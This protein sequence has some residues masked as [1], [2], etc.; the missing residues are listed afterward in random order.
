MKQKDLKELK[1]ETTKSFL[2]GTSYV[3]EFNTKVPIY[4][5]KDNKFRIPTFIWGE[6]PEEILD[7]FLKFCKKYKSLYIWNNKLQKYEI[8]D[9]VIKD[10]KVF[11]KEEL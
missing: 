6:N 7:E 3:V 4:F 5:N 9:I 8:F 10:N 1:L 11:I 2:G